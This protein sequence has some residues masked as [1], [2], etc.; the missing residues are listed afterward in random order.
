MFCLRVVFA[1]RVSVRVGCRR[2]SRV[3][4]CVLVHVDQ[5]CVLVHVGSECCVLAHIF[6]VDIFVCPCWHADLITPCCLMLC[7]TLQSLPRVGTCWAGLGSVFARVE[8]SDACCVVSCWL[9]GDCLSCR[10]H[11]LL[12]RIQVLMC[13]SVFEYAACCVSVSCWSISD[14]PPPMVRGPWIFLRVH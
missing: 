2:M 9:E 7:I 1:H 3:A 11:L 14:N 8:S 10:V 6:I 5:S 4:C 13:C 12:F